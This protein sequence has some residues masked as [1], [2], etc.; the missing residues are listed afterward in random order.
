MAVV[1]LVVLTTASAHARHRR[2]RAHHAHQGAQSLFL[3]ADPHVPLAVVTGAHIDS[4]PFSNRHCGTRHQWKTLGTHWKALDAWGQPMGVYTAATKDDYDVTG[5]AELS[6]APQLKDDLSHVFVSAGSAWHPSASA[7]WVVPAA[8]RASLEALAKATIPDASVPANRVWTQCSSIPTTSRFFHVPGRGDW[9]IATSNAG[10][11]LAR[12]ESRG[13]A[14][15]SEDH[16]KTTAHAFE[17]FR[18][19]AVFDMNGDGVPEVVLRSSGGDGWND[20]VLSLAGDDRWHIVAVS[21][22]G[23]TA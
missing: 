13:W 20:V 7:E 10:W 11:L 2:A 18:P 5:C 1:G 22:G 21:P 16:S 9:A 14:V 6:F 4:T 17:C 12:D 15:R 8:K 23:S 3:A 19:V